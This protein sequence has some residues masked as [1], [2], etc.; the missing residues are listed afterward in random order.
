MLTEE[1]IIIRDINSDIKDESCKKDKILLVLY[2]ISILLIGSIMVSHIIG[3]LVSLHKASNVNILLMIFVL[4][5]S[6]VV[7]YYCHIIVHE[8]GHIIMGKLTGYHFHSY[9]IF[10]IMILK[11]DGKWKIKKYAAPGSLG[12]A[13]MIP[14]EK[15]EGKYPWFLYNAGGGL[16]N[17]ILGLMVLVIYIFA[18]DL[19]VIIDVVLYSF[20]MIGI[21]LGF[22]NLFPL[23]FTLM[24][25][26]GSCMVTLHKDEIARDC[27]YK[28]L[29][30]VGQLAQNKSYKDMPLEYYQLPEGANYENLLISSRKIHELEYYY[31]IEDY[32]SAI[33]LLNETV[34]I[35]GIAKGLRLSLELERLF[36]ECMHE[37]RKDIVEQICTKELLGLLLQGRDMVDMQRIHMAYEGLYNK[38]Y[39]KANMHYERAMK[40][41]EKYPMNGIANIERRF[42]KMVKDKI[43]K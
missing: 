42:L 26:D 7:S 22:M 3:I 31:D 19:P 21:L 36:F 17:I 16:I 9:R 11:E 30:T 29:Y 24:M 8:L 6:L 25:N 39:E 14:P 38:N 1:R 34:Y 28:Q 20:F 27:F 32:S 12:Q 4:I 37:P 2:Y 18:P 43:G 40:L 41:L 35:P 13:I 23:P 33:K 5:I 10:S 15:K